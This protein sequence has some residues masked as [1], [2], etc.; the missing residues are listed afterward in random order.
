MRLPSLPDLG[1]L[2]ALAD[3]MWPSRLSPV[4]VREPRRAEEE[5]MAI[6]VTAEGSRRG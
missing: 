4:S 1:A 6:S 2:F 5:K 3:G